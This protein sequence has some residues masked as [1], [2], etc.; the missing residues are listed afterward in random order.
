MVVV[1]NVANYYR[2][3]T[4]CKCNKCYMCNVGYYYEAGTLCNCMGLYT[5]QLQHMYHLHH[6]RRIQQEPYHI[7]K[8][9]YGVGREGPTVVDKS[10]ADAVLY[11]DR[12]EYRRRSRFATHPSGVG[13]SR[14]VG[15]Y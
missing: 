10:T 8:Y 12:S 11:T 6:H 7:G 9:R 13:P 2:T 15:R 5:D 4:W 1:A 3:Y 14:R